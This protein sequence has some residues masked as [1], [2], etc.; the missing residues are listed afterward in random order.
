MEKQPRLQDAREELH[1]IEDEIS[2]VRDRLAEERGEKGP[3][4]YDVGEETEAAGQPVDDTI[5]PPG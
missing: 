2:E 4:F 5:V 1:H 3:H